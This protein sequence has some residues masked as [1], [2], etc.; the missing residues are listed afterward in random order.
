M[1]LIT[2]SCQAAPNVWGDLTCQPSVATNL[3]AVACCGHSLRHR[4]IPRDEICEVSLL[5]CSTPL[6]SSAICLSSWIFPAFLSLQSHFHRLFSHSSF[7]RISSSSIFFFFFNTHP[8]TPP[9]RLCWIIQ[10][11]QKMRISRTIEFI[12]CS[13]LLAYVLEIM[14]ERSSQIR[15]GCEVSITFFLPLLHLINIAAVALYNLMR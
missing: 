6:S 7:S 12:P 15:S 9:I 3:A 13:V 1:N 14:Q 10:E 11:K 2:T 8:P 5:R 4:E